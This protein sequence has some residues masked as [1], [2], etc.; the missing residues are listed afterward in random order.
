MSCAELDKLRKI[1]S[2]IKQQLKAKVAESKKW[3]DPDASGTGKTDFEPF[4]KH[5][6]AAV[7]TQIEEHLSQHKCG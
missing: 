2:Q 6:L 5:Q 4:L 7:T 3:A 1:A